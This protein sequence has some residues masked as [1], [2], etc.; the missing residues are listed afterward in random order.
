[1]ATIERT[2]I[3]PLRREFINTAKYKRSKRAVNAVRRFLQRHMK[4][5]NVKISN[6]INLE[7]WK[8]GI[9]NPPGKIKVNVTK[10]D[11]GLVKAELFGVKPKVEEKKE[12]KT[13]KKE[14]VKEEKKETK[15]VEEKKEEVK[16]EKTVKKAPKKV[17]K[18]ETK[19]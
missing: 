11:A 12:E 19:S 18:E 9:R 4:S 15:P 13:E 16:K 14:E 2:Y 17:K 8:H 10:D 7:I 1:M 3:I 5:D 6:N